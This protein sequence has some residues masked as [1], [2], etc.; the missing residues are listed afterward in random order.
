MFFFSNIQSGYDIRETSPY[1][2]EALHEPLDNEMLTKGRNKY[3]EGKTP[4]LAIHEDRTQD[5]G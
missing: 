2:G 3:S 4:R 1:K 5:L